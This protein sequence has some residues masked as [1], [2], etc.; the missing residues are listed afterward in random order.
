MAIY[1]GST[2]IKEL[3]LG[4][5]KI[6]EA[7]LG[8]TLVYR[9]SAY[10]PDEVVFES[11]TAGTYTLDLLETGRYEVTVVAGGGGAKN[12]RETPSYSKGSGASGSCFKGEIQIT[13]GSLSIVVGAGGTKS[14]SRPIGN[15][16]GGVSSIGDLVSCPSQKAYGTQSTWFAYQ[17]NGAPTVTATVYST[18][19]NSAGNN[20]SIKMNSLVA[21]TGG[22]SVYDGTATGYGAGGSVGAQSSNTPNPFEDGVVGYVKIV[23]KSN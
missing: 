19:I 16:V 20:G 5:T 15:M 14:S 3:Y 7:Y 23:Y 22:K 13:K 12:V 4:G 6:K 11:S 2:K 1:L 9:A 10:A 17:N 18:S 8:S 21:H